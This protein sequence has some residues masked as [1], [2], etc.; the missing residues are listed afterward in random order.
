[1]EF[2]KNVISY[3]QDNED[4]ILYHLLS[5]VKSV[6]WI[7]VGA[8]DPVDISVTKLFSD[9][10]GI[11]IN[12]EPQKQYE[13]RYLD[14]RPRD[15]NLR[16]G[17]GE[18]KGVMRL[19]GEGV[20]ASFKQNAGKYEEVPVNTLEEICDTYIQ[21]DREIHFLKI[22]VEGFEEQV[23]KGM[24]FEKFRPWIV[25]LEATVP[26]STIQSYQKWEYLLLNNKYIFG[27]Q[28]GINRYY[29]SYEKYELLKDK[30]ID[31]SKILEMYGVSTDSSDYR[32]KYDCLRVQYDAVVNSTS[33]KITYPLRM[34]S[35]KL[36]T[37]FR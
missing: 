30:L 33:W 15:I 5:N 25:M 19:Y 20:G 1:M 23:L 27:R 14:L 34:I 24:N 28:Y 4:L 31:E 8:N 37:I 26:G 12:I 6:F 9:M 32:E 11:G 2:K 16:M 7:D 22:D 17:C 13:Q 21:P 29:F 3:A 18:K 10:G 36:K 35:E